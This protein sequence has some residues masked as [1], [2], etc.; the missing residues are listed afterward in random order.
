VYDA[1]PG[2]KIEDGE[3][4]EEAAVREVAEETG[5]EIRV[6]APVLTLSNEG[7]REFYFDALEATGK[8]VLGGP[9]ALRTGPNNEYVLGWIALGELAHAPIRPRALKDWLLARDWN[10]HPGSLPAR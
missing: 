2:G 4:P 9:E 7:R 10:Q 3:T 1:I 8:P 6:R 5:I